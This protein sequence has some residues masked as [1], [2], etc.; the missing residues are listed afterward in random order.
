MAADAQPWTAKLFADARNH[1]SAIERQAA[2]GR[3]ISGKWAGKKWNVPRPLYPYA[4]GEMPVTHPHAFAMHTRD[5]E[6]RIS[7]GSHDER[8][9]AV[10]LLHAM[11]ELDRIKENVDRAADDGLPPFWGEA[12]PTGVL[13]HGRKA[14]GSVLRQED[15]DA[16]WDEW[17]L[18]WRCAYGAELMRVLWER[19]YLNLEVEEIERRPPDMT[20]HRLRLRDWLGISEE[21]ARIWPDAMLDAGATKV[22]RQEPTV[23]SSNPA[24]YYLPV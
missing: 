7:P 4:G 3:S 22:S 6:V 8:L 2:G 24:T 14:T 5:R 20:L 19:D 16:A 17:E 11:G 9:W 1:V 13:A 10:R 23:R 21:K 18:L 15:V 12:R